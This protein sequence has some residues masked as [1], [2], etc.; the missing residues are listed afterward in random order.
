[1]AVIKIFPLRDVCFTTN[2]LL[3]QKNAFGPSM[4]CFTKSF[5]FKFWRVSVLFVGP[6]IPQFWTA[7]DDCP[8]FQA[9]ADPYLYAFLP[10]CNGFLRFT[11][12]ETPAD[13]LGVSM[14]AKE[15][16]PQT[17]TNKTSTFGTS[18]APV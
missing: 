6:L 1:M 7:S 11:S 12:G 13:F 4:M 15:F 3:L 8:G 5:Y 14:A 10:A 17:Y 2:N 18:G 9:R 16:Y